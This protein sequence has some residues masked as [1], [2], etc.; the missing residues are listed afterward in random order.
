MIAQIVGIKAVID[1]ER[2]RDDRGLHHQQV[3]WRSRLVRR[4]LRHD[5]RSHAWRGFGVLPYFDR[6]RELPAEDALG[7]ADARKIRRRKIAF[8]ALSRIA[9]FDDL[10]PLKLEPD[11]DLVMV[12]TRRGDS[13]RCKARHPSRLEIDA[14]RPRLPARA[15]LGHR[16][17]RPSS[18][19]RPCA[20]RLRRL[21]DAGTQRRRSRRNRGAGGETPGLGLLDVTTVMTAQKSLTRVEAVHAGTKRLEAYEIHIGHTEGAEP[22]V[23]LPSRRRAGRRGIPGRTRVRQLSARPVRFGWFPRRISCADWNCRRRQR[24]RARWKTRST[25]SPITSKGI[26]MSRVCSRSRAE[27]LK[28][29]SAASG[30]PLRLIAGKAKPQPARRVPER[31]ATRCARGQA[32]PARPR[33]RRSH[34]AETAACRRRG[35][36]P[37][38]DLCIE[39]QQS[40]A[41]RAWSWSAQSRSSKARLPMAIA[42]AETGHGPDIAASAAMSASLPRRSPAAVRQ[43]HRTFQ[44][45]AGS[46]APAALPL[47]STIDRGRHRQNFRR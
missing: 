26:S 4:R 19:R 24:Y 9:N 44:R 23:P 46:E 30:V 32:A 2:C 3:P 33:R 34:K 36:S 12:A 45:S 15:R 20:R 31:C 22:R 6:A 5:R 25:R 27:Q 41:R 10:D 43:G 29:P 47:T 7:L 35:S 40:R 13:R 14:R 11:V 17:F 1:P 28:T 38:P 39:P 16:S 42:A 8:L 21:P 37:L 18:S